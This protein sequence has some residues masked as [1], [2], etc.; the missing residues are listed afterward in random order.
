[1]TQSPLPS[2][3]GPP[4]PWFLPRSNGMATASLILGVTALVSD[5]CC[6]CCLGP[7]ASLLAIIFGHV[8]LYQIRRSQGMEAGDG[9]AIAGLV[10]GYVGLLIQVFIAILYFIGLCIGAASGSCNMRI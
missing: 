4:Q 2:L 10:T 3:P 8:A 6:C 1:M 9:L 5:F 7:F